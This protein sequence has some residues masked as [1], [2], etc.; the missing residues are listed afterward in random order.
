M[1]DTTALTVRVTVTDAWDRVPLTVP[2]D[3]TIRELRRQALEAALD[4]AEQADRYAVKFRGGFV[5]D[6]DRT[7]ADLDVPDGAAL[8]VLAARRRPVR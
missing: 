4:T 3:T 2:A 1:T 5:H 7:L 8:I 6:L